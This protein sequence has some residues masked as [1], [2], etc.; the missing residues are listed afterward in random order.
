MMR[1]LLHQEGGELKQQ[2]TN[3]VGSAKWVI[4]IDNIVNKNTDYV[5]GIFLVR[6][7]RSSNQFLPFISFEGR[8][9]AWNQNILKNLYRTKQSY[10]LF[11]NT[12]FRLFNNIIHQ[13]FNNTI[14]QLLNKAASGFKLSSL[15]YCWCFYLSYYWPNSHHSTE[16]GN[17]DPNYWMILFSSH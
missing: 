3:S 1:C 10:Q 17:T 2:N 12:I 7:G 16:L 5:V 4:W 6:R 15:P 14:Y 9:K 8:G 11:N 13:L